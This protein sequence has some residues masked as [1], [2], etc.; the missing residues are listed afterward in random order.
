MVAMFFP[1]GG[2]DRR[3]T[4]GFDG[5]GGGVR[6]V[7]RRGVRPGLEGAHPPVGVHQHP[8]PGERRSGDW[9]VTAARASQ[10]AGSVEAQA[11]WSG[12][13]R[14]STMGNTPAPAG[15]GGGAP[16]CSATR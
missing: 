10:A 12:S 13:S 7:P 8:G 2:S 5:R 6:V 14:V 9:P 1:A 15:S 4:D 16:G 11:G 3:G